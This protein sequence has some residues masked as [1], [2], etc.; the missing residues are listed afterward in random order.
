VLEATIHLR[1]RYYYQE[2]AKS[3]QSSR[4]RSSSW[5]WFA[6][7]PDAI[8]ERAHFDGYMFSG[9]FFR[10]STPYIWQQGR[11]VDRLVMVDYA[12]CF[13]ILREETAFDTCSIEIPG[14]LM[15]KKDHV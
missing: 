9:S 14:L 4:T 7:I 5:S 6:Q 10:L 8:S 12:I 3:N 1:P 13:S 11:W 15:M 2:P